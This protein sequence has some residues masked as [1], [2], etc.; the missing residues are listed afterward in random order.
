MIK[1]WSIMDLNSK[2]TS[3]LIEIIK[4]QTTTISSLRQT[5]E[6]VNIESRLLREQIDYLTKKLFGIK[7]EKSS[8][9][10]GQILLDGMEFGQFDEAET[11]SDE[12]EVEEV[13]SKK[14]TRKGYSR[15]KALFDL[16]QEDRHFTLKD[17]EKICEI[18]GDKRHFAGKKYLRSEIEYIPAT[19]KIINIYQETWECRTCRKENRPYLL[20]SSVDAP[21]IQH[22]MASPSSVAWT[23]YQKY[24]NHIPLYRQ[25][26][27]WQ[28]LG[29]QVKRS[30][31]SN[32]IL[33]TSDEYLEKMV[34]R[35]Q[36]HLLKQN[37]LHADETTIQ[38][39]NEE[40]R[41]KIK[42]V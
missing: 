37:Y 18:D 38:V 35:L 10:T 1:G 4:E 14:K 19:M 33:K 22:S 20:Q 39:M 25:E 3:F 23:M 28:N 40:D 16:P 30:T 5:L 8:V 11:Y 9:L 36:Y 13:I 29:I 34:N 26:K 21:L 7:S 6:E 27:D 24:V 31:L 42:P 41:K 32:W 17:S 2:D 15:E 12:E